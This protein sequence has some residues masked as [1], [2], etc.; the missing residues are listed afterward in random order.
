MSKST[1]P[2][3][4]S[5]R[6]N[7]SLEQFRKLA[8]D[9]H[10]SL[11]AGNVEAISLLRDFHPAYSNATDQQITDAEFSLRD[12]Q[13]VLARE[14]KFENWA[15]LKEFMTWDVAV[16][17]QDIEGIR[18]AL[19]EKPERICQ[20]IR[21]PARKGF[22]KLAPISYCNNNPEMM[23]LLL[24][25]GAELNVPGE[26]MLDNEST[27]EF[28]DFAAAQGA[29]L[30][31]KYYNWPVLTCFVGYGPNIPSIKR[32]LAHGADVNI[33]ADGPGVEKWRPYAAGG[34]TP[35]HVATCSS[36]SVRTG[37]KFK[38]DLDIEKYKEVVRI[39]LDA[40]ADVH[41]TT[42]VDGTS[43]EGLIYQGET[44]LH[45]AAACGDEEMIQLLLDHGADIGKR[46]A[47]NET[48]LDYAKRYERPESIV[49]L[50]D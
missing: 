16:Q 35:L 23:E 41:A 6:E 24:K 38:R 37:G 3:M 2:Q 5:L 25:H 43:D 32:M 4:K 42:F 14:Y 30:N 10:K 46:T 27:P 20:D 22:V 7:L 11:T 8:K 44:P 49:R 40:G 48:P 45:F 1:S 50:L 17:A 19:R 12:A 36:Y 39:L 47:K 33:V 26:S 29:D 34:N 28:V 15:D 31:A 21:R 18:K 13:L 9:L